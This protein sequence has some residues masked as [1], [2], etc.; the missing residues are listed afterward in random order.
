MDLGAGEMGLIFFGQHSLLVTRI[1]VMDPGPKG[2]IVL[3]PLTPGLSHRKII[4]GAYISY[5]I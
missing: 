4:Y 2:A 5:I 3:C 1:Q